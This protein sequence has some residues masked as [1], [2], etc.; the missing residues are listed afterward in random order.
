MWLVTSNNTTHTH[1]HARAFYHLHSLAGNSAMHSASIYKGCK[2]V[3]M[4]LHVGTCTPT[5]SLRQTE[6]TKRWLSY[7]WRGLRT[8][9]TCYLSRGHANTKSVCVCVSVSECEIISRTNSSL[10]NWIH[11]IFFYIWCGVTS[12]KR[13]QWVVCI[14]GLWIEGGYM[15]IHL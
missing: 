5:F 12:L 2:W 4:S 13:D 14:G 3:C 1:A 15:Y 11:C 6:T 10:R 7:T 8:C 9:T